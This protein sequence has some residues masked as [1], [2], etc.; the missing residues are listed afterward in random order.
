MSGEKAVAR[1]DT[2]PLLQRDPMGLV[3][4]FAQS[5]YF[6]DARDLS[7][8][9]VK[10]AFGEELGIGVGASMVGI[11]IIEGK[12]SLSANLLGA[13][14][15]RSTH[16]DYKP[17]EISDE[18]AVVAFYV[19]GEEIGQS[20]FTLA[21]ART[22]GLI[23]SKSGWERFPQAMLFARAL[24]QGV[25]WYCPDVTAGSPAYTPEELGAEVDPS[26]EPVYVESQIVEP[27]EA[28]ALDPERVEHLSKGYKL[29]KP[30]LEE[31]A[32]NALDGLNVLLGS[33]GI[34]GFDPNTP[35]AEQLA[36]LTEEQAAALDAELQKLIEAQDGQAGGES[37]AE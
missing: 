5:G 35:V 9:V 34:D 19:D 4:H 29:A 16:Y 1:R 12:P 25:R 14:V 22:A 7:Q 8:A 17:V 21:Q 28:P 37:D 10:A 3:Q 6:K 30:A 36:R 2:T 15:K 18:K 24:S 31:N 13:L 27:D 20:E 33:L 26:G 23:R 11:H 32:V